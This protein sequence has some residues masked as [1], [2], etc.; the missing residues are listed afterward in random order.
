MRPK[1]R[2]FVTDAD[3]PSKQSI[4]RAALALFVRHGLARTN[5]RMIGK[6]AGYTNPALFKFFASKDALALYLFERCYA[7][8]YGAVERAASEGPFKEALGKVL[9]AFLAVMDEDLEA[10]LF[11]Q[12]TLRELW[13][14]VSAPLRKRSILAVLRALF[15]R[16]RREG[17]VD[18]FP[19][20]DIPVAALVGLVAQFGRMTYFGEIR[21]PIRRWK[22]ELERALSR[23]VKKDRR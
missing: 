2:C 12:D 1:A 11:V 8:L 10:A 7:R 6:E 22:P 21:G 17:A 19:S 5:V 9:D 16:G 23:M 15:R 4:L 13:P 18:G 3:A 20:P 14:R